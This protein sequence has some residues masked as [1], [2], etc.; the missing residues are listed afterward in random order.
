[1]WRVVVDEIRVVGSRCG[2]FAPAL[3]LLETGLVAV[4]DLI[5]EEF[6]LEK[7][8]QAMSRAAEKGVMKV[9]LSMS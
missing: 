1:M 8:V 2:H 4:D 7:G 6:S 5:S 3:R 9:L